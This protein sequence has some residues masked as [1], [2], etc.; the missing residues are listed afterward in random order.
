MEQEEEPAKGLTKMW[1]IDDCWKPREKGGSTR[2][3]KWSKVSNA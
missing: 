2:K 1:F 3:R